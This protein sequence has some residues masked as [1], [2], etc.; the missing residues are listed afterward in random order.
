[1]GVWVDGRVRLLAPSVS[2]W[3]GEWV[4]G[5][6]NGR[7]CGRPTEWV[8]GWV[9]GWLCGRMGGRLGGRMSEW[10]WVGERVIR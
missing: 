8:Y 10:V 1:M 2:G 5:R 3:G 7:V 4:W 9:N 6:A